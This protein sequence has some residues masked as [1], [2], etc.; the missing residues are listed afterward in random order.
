MQFGCVV[1]GEVC[2]GTTLG[3]GALTLGSGALT[4]GVGVRVC[5]GMNTLGDGAGI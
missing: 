4:L 2:A 1:V 5:N 3:S